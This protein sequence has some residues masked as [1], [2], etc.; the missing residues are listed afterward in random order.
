MCR[1]PEHCEGHCLS[2]VP[3]KWLSG[4]GWSTPDDRELCR[5]AGWAVFVDCSGWTALRKEA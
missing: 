5:S 1:A 2:T 3:H 4:L